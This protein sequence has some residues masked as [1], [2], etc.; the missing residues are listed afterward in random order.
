MERRL[1]G[2]N[3]TDRNPPS[4][5]SFLLA[6]GEQKRK[7]GGAVVESLLVAHQ[8][9]FHRRKVGGEPIMLGIPEQKLRNPDFVSI[10]CF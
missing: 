1:I 10:P 2:Y 9:C 4:L 7:K 5:F 8:S 3:G 6:C